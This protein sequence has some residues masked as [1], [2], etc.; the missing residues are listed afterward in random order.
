MAGEYVCMY[1]YGHK[2]LPAVFAGL[3]FNCR[4]VVGPR[5]FHFVD[6]VISR[7]VRVHPFASTISKSRQGLEDMAVKLVVFVI[8]LKL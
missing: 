3:S 7:A 8:K 5:P 6:G 1:V 2:A 4:V